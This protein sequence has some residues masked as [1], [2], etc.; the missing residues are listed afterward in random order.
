MGYANTS[1]KPWLSRAETGMHPAVLRELKQ[2][3]T[4]TRLPMIREHIQPKTLI[5]THYV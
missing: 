2:A 1:E 3:F 4:R 5:Y